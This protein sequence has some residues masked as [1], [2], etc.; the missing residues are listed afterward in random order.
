MNVQ[1]EIENIS[2]LQQLY[3]RAPALAS[4]EIQKGIKQAAAILLNATV[5]EEPID[6]GKLRQSTHSDIKK[7]EAVIEILKPA[8]DYAFFVHNG[9]PA[10]NGKLMAIEAAAISPRA[11]ARLPPA[12][13]K[14]MIFFTKRKAIPPNP[15]MQ[16]A[17]DKSR[18]KV[19]SIFEAVAKRI[20]DGM[21]TK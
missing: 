1:L 6:T 15:F 17:V 21:A 7:D 5:K 11:R 2:E 18:E 14:G 8:V 4:S 10:V 3:K 19:M 13:K 20:A 16:R 12:N 9:S